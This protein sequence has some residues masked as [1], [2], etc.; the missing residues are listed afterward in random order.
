MKKQFLIAPVLL[1]A[2]A[3]APSSN[4]GMTATAS[5]SSQQPT[6][7]ASAPQQ[8]QPAPQTPRPAPTPLPP[9]GLLALSD[10]G[11]EFAPDARLIV[12]MA[13]LDAAGWDA[14]G[15]PTQFRQMVRRDYAKLD[16]ALRARLRDFFTRYQLPGTR[17]PAEQAA[18]YVSLAYTLGPAP[19]FEAPPRSEDLPS[20]VLDVLDFAPLAREFYRSTGMDER[21]PEYLRAHRA[22]ADQLRLPT[23]RMVRDVLS[24][25]HLQPVTTMVE[26][27]NATDPSRADAKRRDAQ[28]R[29]TVMREKPRRFL[30]VPDLLAAPG[31]VNFRVIGDD[32]Y[33]IIPPGTDPA[34]SELR[35]AYIQYL[36]DPLVIRFSR[37]IAARRAEIKQLLD[38]Q[39]AKGNAEASADVFL[40]V[41]RSLVVA[42]DARMSEA[43]RLNVLQNDASARL[44]EVKTEEARA[45]IIKETRETRARIEDATTAQLAEAYER[46][47]VLA[48][49]FADQ[50]RGLETSGFDISNFFS[51]MVASFQVT[52]ESRRPAEYAA[53]VQRFREARALA[54]AS[55]EA[56]S[57]AAAEAAPQTEQRKA[58]LKGLEEVEQLVRLKNYEEADAR[59]R[60]MTGEFRGE[61]RVFYALAQVASVSAQDAFDENLQVERL[62]RALSFYRQAIMAASRDTDGALISRAHAAAGRILVFLERKEEALKEFDAAI[63]LGEVEGG[64]Y[65]EAL[66]QKRRLTGQP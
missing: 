36:V 40:I 7:A 51:D 42:A 12:V 27:V 22:E 45:P 20:G 38:E 48:F 56:S 28:K 25:L 66:E 58:L 63:A 49:F 1:C 65:R 17:T 61:P 37:A 50:L 13:A 6:P 46:G 43:G 10:Y 9:S 5:P 41:A 60:A 18:R 34:A 57:A 62:T 59:L 3:F 15:E 44:S 39:V 64:A 11:V 23:S 47:A 55:A 16:P 19:G 8:Q 32:Y 29:V 52:R 2:Q 14:G 30:V 4:A 53:A 33:A 35:R 31:A 54:R 21:L 24:Y 26:R